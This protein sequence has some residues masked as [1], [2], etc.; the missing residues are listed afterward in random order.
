MYHRVIRSKAFSVSYIE[1]NNRSFPFNN[2]PIVYLSLFQFDF[3]V[4]PTWLYNPIRKFRSIVQST[5]ARVAE[6]QRQADIQ[7][8]RRSTVCSGIAEEFYDRW[9]EHIVIECG[10]Y[11][12][13]GQ[14]FCPRCL[15]ILRLE[16]PQG[17]SYYPG[18]VCR[19]GKYVGGCGADI[20]CGRCESE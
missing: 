11:D 9:D 4:H 16:Y 20:M 10:E 12:R 19:H 18:D 5:K 8:L 13:N 6:W 3:E 1:P 17:W 2:L 14:Q 15:S 7:Q